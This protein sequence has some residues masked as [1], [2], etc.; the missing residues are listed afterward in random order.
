MSETS[1]DRR[2][3]MHAAVD[4]ELDAGGAIAFERALA[5]D[6]ELAKEFER[7]RALR[8][9]L[10]EKFAG[11]AAPPA[12]RA[13]IESSV[14]PAPAFSRRHTLSLAASLAASLVVGIGIGGGAMFVELGQRG[15]PDLADALV[16]GH[17]R[18]LLA[19][20]PVDVA[21]N[22]LHNVR[23]WFGAHIAVSPPT[24]DLAAQGFS[25]VGGRVDVIHG[26]PAPTLVY[27]YKEHYISVTVLPAAGVTA[28]TVAPAGYHIVSWRGEGFNCWA[29][30]DSDL[31]Q[32]EDFARAFKAAVHG[33]SSSM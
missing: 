17:R 14:R 32:L 31:P 9:A 7:Q 29:I 21:S 27:R 30:S 19:A 13:R 25:L 15:A 20:S 11:E 33:S 23:H 26:A 22:D 3:M 6:P 2:L 18:A 4:G 24:P 16:A 12:L 5:D 10:R 1:I 28:P 8:R